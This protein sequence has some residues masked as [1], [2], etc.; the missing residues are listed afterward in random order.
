MQIG[1][2]EWKMRDGK[3]AIVAV[4]RRGKQ[5][6]WIGWFEDCESAESWTDDGLL[7]FNDETEYDI[8]APWTSPIAAGHNLFTLESKEVGTTGPRDVSL[9]TTNSVISS[10]I[11]SY[12]WPNSSGGGR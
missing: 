9:M 11:W 2:G 7:S 12:T 8:I 6:P 1:I 10:N 4:H 5:Y 3:K